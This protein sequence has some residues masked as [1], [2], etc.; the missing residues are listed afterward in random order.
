MLRFPSFLIARTSHKAYEVR[1]A[2]GYALLRSDT[3]SAS[4]RACVRACVRMCVCVCVVSVIVK[5]PVLPP[6]VVDGRWA[7]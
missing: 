3:L 1:V 6:S 2:E 7:L 5:R 4:V